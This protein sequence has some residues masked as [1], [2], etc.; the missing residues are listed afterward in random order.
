VED[1]L[2]RL[3]VLSIQGNE[4]AWKI[5]KNYEKFTGEKADGALAEQWKDAVATVG[6]ITGQ[7]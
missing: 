6:W 4:K 3:E 7:E 5:L 1:D 2:G